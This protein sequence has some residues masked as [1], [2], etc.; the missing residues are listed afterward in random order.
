ME[1]GVLENDWVLIFDRMRSLRHTDSYSFRI[2][3][4]REEVEYGIGIAGEFIDRME[5]LLNK[6]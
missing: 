3:P 5:K 4:T 2:H 1:Q 6:T